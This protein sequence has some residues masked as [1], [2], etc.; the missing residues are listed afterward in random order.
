MTVSKHS[1]QQEKVKTQ[2]KKEK[3]GVALGLKISA[4]GSEPN[5]VTFCPT[6]KKTHLGL[7]SIHKPKKWFC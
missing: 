2:G 1:S 3:G 4:L 5:G 6:L 7:D